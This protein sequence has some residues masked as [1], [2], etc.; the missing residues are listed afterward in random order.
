MN[1]NCNCIYL[2]KS[3]INKCF[4]GLLLIIIIIIIIIN[5]CWQTGRQGIIISIRISW[6]WTR[7]VVSRRSA[8]AWIIRSLI[9]L[10]CW[11]GRIWLGFKMRN[12]INNKNI[13]RTFIIRIMLNIYSWTNRSI[14]GIWVSIIMKRGW[15]SKVA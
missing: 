8:R 11:K 6:V 5:S 12:F 3:S 15:K 14:K 4:L 7:I 1:S 2:R 13:I 10:S 9:L